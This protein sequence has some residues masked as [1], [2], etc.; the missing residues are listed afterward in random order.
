MSYKTPTPHNSKRSLLL[1]ALS[2]ETHVTKWHRKQDETDLDSQPSTGG[3]NPNSGPESVSVE[4]YDQIYNL[5]GSDAEYIQQLA[6]L[7]NAKMR[8][9]A[10][11]G[12]SADSLRY[13]VLAAL[14]I[15]DE[16]LSLRVRYDALAGGNSRSE[17]SMRSRAGT[18]SE[19]LSE[20]FVV[21]GKSIFRLRAWNAV[22]SLE[23][24][25]SKQSMDEAATASTDYMVLVNALN[26]APVAFEL[27]TTDPLGAARLRGSEQ[28]KQL[29]REGGGV[30]NSAVVAR[31]LGITRQGV[32]RRRT[33]NRLIGLTQGRR[34]YAYPLFQFVENTTL[35]GLEEVLKVLGAGDPWMQ[36]IFFVNPNDRLDESTPEKELRAGNLKG[37]LRAAVSYGEQGAA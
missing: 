11:H 25:L 37:V 33:Q 23:K 34:G 28:K 22:L 3:L 19:M 18:L 30:V 2:E 20:M 31:L 24:S 14:N 4:I 7:V 15:V 13:A 12:G 35:Q 9:V 36:L 27:A 10:A 5:R 32:D 17:D 29:I 8:A 16:L 21:K 26:A 6:A 1:E